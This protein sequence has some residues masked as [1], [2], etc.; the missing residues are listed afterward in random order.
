MGW[1]DAALGVLAFISETVGTVTGFGSSTFFVPTAV[2][3]ESFHLV[4]ALTAILHVFGNLSKLLLFRSGVEYKLMVKLALPS[5]LLAGAGAL[6]TRFVPIEILKIFL[7]L[8]LMF[9]AAVLILMKS[10]ITRLS[11]R[12]GIIL[13]AVSGFF[14]GLVGTGGAIRAVA[15][16]SMEFEKS[17]FVFASAAIDIGGD[18]LRAGIYLSQGYMNWDQW[19]YLPLLGTAAVL[20]A[21]SGRHLL[22][23]MHQSQF[24][25]AVAVLIFLS[26]S[27][28]V[29]EGLQR[30][31]I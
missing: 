17:S 2:F 10:S 14:T 18:I 31:S 5:I 1:H 24:E 12:S 6:L 29:A 20:G 21:W 9:L 22:K 27:A 13:T 19:F 26:G 30:L 3:F 4:L 8:I 23:L 11:Q 28:L 25:R 15:L 16:A 7:G